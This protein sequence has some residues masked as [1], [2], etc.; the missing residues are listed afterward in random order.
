MNLL[1]DKVGFNYNCF[2]VLRDVSFQVEAGS[3]VCVL[4][5]NG[6]GKSTLFKCIL[7]FLH[8]QQGTILLAGENIASMPPQV[9]AGKT[10]YI[11]QGQAGHFSYSS[12]E[13]VLMGTTANKGV[14]FSPGRKHEEQAAEALERL[15]IG[16]LTY[17]N[18]SHL[19]GGER[20]MVLIAR[21]MAQQV[22]ILIM[23]E[24]CSGLDYGNQIRVMECVKELS[25]QGY[26]ILL[27]THSPEQAF[28]Y[29]D[30]ALVLAEGKNRCFGKP[31]EILSDEL[32]EEIYGV[33]V[34]P[35]FYSDK[36]F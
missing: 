4:G 22:K 2:P 7:G 25:R 26:L 31:E 10:A 9:L 11:P 27:S 30:F 8:P 24:P 1:V 15:G 23:D 5:S 13:I 29:A 20:Q 17:R 18:F 34:R 12:L 16:K 33:R 3:L 21:A 14:F 6:A 36:K 35:R 28:L 19:S 32:F